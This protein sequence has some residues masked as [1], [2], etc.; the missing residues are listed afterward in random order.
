MKS[1]TYFTYWVG[2]VPLTPPGRIYAIL[3]EDIGTLHWVVVSDQHTW[4]LEQHLPGILKPSCWRN[5]LWTGLCKVFSIGSWPQL[6]GSF[7]TY[8]LIVSEPYRNLHY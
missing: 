3:I 4:N 1:E 2:G 6:A 5:T 7:A 8:Q